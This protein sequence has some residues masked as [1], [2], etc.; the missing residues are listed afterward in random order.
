M[1]QQCCFNVRSSRKACW[2]L[3]QYCNLSCNHCFADAGPARDRIPL[4]LESLLQVLDSLRVH[5]VRYIVFSGGEPLLH[6]HLEP[7][8]EASVRFGIITGV[9]TNAIAANGSLSRQ[10]AAAGLAKATVSLDG[11]TAEVYEAVRNAPKTFPHVIRGIQALQDAGITVSTNTVLHPLNVHS[12]DDIVELADSLR[13]ER[14]AF[15]VPVCSGS[16]DDEVSQFRDDARRI[17]YAKNALIQEK[18]K[19][20][21]AVDVHDPQC[22]ESTCPAGKEILGVTERGEIISCLVKEWVHAPSALAFTASA[23]LSLPR[24]AIR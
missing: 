9:A 2:R 22:F 20:A 17:T 18:L 6:P 10:L 7:L 21:V 5:E 3:A 24:G 16:R 1:I 14:I 8:I 13:V 4:D 23:S 11:A 19:F 12:I 15:T